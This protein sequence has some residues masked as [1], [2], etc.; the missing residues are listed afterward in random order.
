MIV[1]G[2]WTTDPVTGKVIFLRFDRPL[3]IEHDCDGE[4]VTEDPPAR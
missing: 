2:I 4:Q 1:T 3:E